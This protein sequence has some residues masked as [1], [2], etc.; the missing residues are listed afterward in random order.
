MHGPGGRH[1]GGD[2]RC[3]APTGCPTKPCCSDLIHRMVCTACGLIGADVRPDWTH[4][5]YHS[6]ATPSDQTP[7]R[8]ESV[9]NASVDLAAN[10]RLTAQVIAFEFRGRG[11]DERTHKI[12][13]SQCEPNH[14]YFRSLMSMF[15]RTS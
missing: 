1:F 8:S 7:T 4:R 14:T 11:H 15:A 3:L 6:V 2:Q 13:S 10:P 5:H 12:D 9:S